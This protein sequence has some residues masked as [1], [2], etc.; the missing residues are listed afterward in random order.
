MPGQICRVVA[1][2]REM[3]AGAGDGEGWVQREPGLDCRTR[4]IQATKLRKRYAQHKMGMRIISV[5]LDR[6]STPGDRLLPKAQLILRDARVSHPGVSHRIARTES[7]GLDNV[8]LGF[9]GATDK[10]LT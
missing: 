3:G 5:G 8:S 10:N 9:F 6:P 7:E 2:R 1:Q 4:L